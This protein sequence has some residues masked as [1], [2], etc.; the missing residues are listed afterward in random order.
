MSLATEVLRV[1]HAVTPISLPEVEMRGRMVISAHHRPSWKRPKVAAASLLPNQSPRARYRTERGRFITTAPE[2]RHEM[3]WEP[4]KGWCWRSGL[5]CEAM[6]FQPHS[7]IS[8][9]DSLFPT[10]LQEEP[11]LQKLP[12][13]P[14]HRSV[15][16]GRTSF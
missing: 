16:K 5:E 12:E 11:F 14:P 3:R 8:Q 4:R 9:S 2:Q 10:S 6:E 13:R 1:V 15:S 7:Q